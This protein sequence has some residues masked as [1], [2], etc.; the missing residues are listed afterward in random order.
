MAALEEAK[1]A[2][3]L[4]AIEDQIRHGWLSR[5]VSLVGEAPPG[6]NASSRLPKKRLAKR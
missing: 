6:S 5:L 4:I 3:L 1:N 2:S